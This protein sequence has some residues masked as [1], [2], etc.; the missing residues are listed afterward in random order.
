MRNFTTLVPD[1]MVCASA[2]AIAWLGGTQRFMG[3][4][5]RIGFHAAFLV[6]DGR[7]E[8][9]G[10]ANAVLGSY[11]GQLGMSDRAILYMTQAGPTS[12]SW[13]SLDEAKEL[14]VDVAVLPSVGAEGHP[15]SSEGRISPGGLKERAANFVTSMIGHWS[16]PNDLALPVLER[17]YTGDVWYYGKSVTAEAVLSDKRQFASRWPNR[18]C[19]VRSSS[20][21]VTCT[22]GTNVCSVTGIFDWAVA[23][24]STHKRRSGTAAFRYDV[25][26]ATGGVS[27]NSCGEQRRPGSAGRHPDTRT[28]PV[29][30]VRQFTWLRSDAQT[31][32]G[33][34]TSDRLLLAM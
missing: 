26:E 12:M 24:E 30:T 6:Q 29:N 2:C 7:P 34:H 1:G 15:S 14:D 19:T 23:N 31:P 3:R 10:A 13:L 17:L 22:E 25:A 21:T 18:Q 8:E 11:L 27:H 5:S 32:E 28:L 4:S 16:A 20:V 9:K 33:D